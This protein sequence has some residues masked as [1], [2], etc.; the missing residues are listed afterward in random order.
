MANSNLS[1]SAMNVVMVAEALVAACLLLAISAILFAVVA[2]AEPLYHYR[3]GYGQPVIYR[4]RYRPQAT[5]NRG[6]IDCVADPTDDGRWVYRIREMMVHLLWSFEHNVISSM[7]S[8]ENSL[9][10]GVP[11]NSMQWPTF[12]ALLHR[13]SQVSLYFWSAACTQSAKARLLLLVW[14]SAGRD[15]PAIAAAI[16]TVR[17]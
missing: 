7:R 15:T 5:D 1:Q 13:A 12:P 8:W 17:I 10:R 4:I 11:M 14:P 6:I 3:Q 2:G 16:K 9:S